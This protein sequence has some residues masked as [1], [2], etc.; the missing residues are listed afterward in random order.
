DPAPG[1]SAEWRG[2]FVMPIGQASQ[3][4]ALIVL[5]NKRSGSFDEDDMLGIKLLAHRAALAFE[6]ARSVETARRAVQA[7]EDLLA[8]VAQ[9]LGNPLHAIELCTSSLGSDKIHSDPLRRSKQVGLIQRA[10]ERIKR[11]VEDLHHVAAIESGR[12]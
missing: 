12:F 10:T 7:R 6:C 9:D 11:L 3:P 2:W 1:M 5:L 8:V 4:E